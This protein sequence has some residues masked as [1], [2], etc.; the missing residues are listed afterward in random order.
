VRHSSLPDVVPPR[1]SPRC[2]EV[3]NVNGILD[4]LF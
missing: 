3:F 2:C 4:S 1:S